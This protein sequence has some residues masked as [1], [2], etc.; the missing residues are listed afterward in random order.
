MKKWIFWGL[1]VVAGTMW[2]FSNGKPTIKNAGRPVQLIAAFGDSLTAG[3]G[4]AK[5]QAYPA[6]LEKLSGVQ[7]VNLGRS[8]ETAVQARERLGDVLVLQPQLV[9]IEFG[10]NDFMQS[11]SREAA[12]AAVAHMVETVQ[13]AGAMAVIVDT[14]G[15]GM[16]GYTNAYKKLAREKHALFVPGIMKGIFNKR[17]L[18][19]D[20]IH[21]NAAGYELIAQ[22]I[23]K[24]IKPYLK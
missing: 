9:L 5:M 17:S 4:A 16:E 6:V 7:V 1:L 13:A 21:P 10:A 18:K 22:R 14:G 8:G 11:R 15:P 23:Y 12:V 2:Y 20:M 24:T 3:Q 19:S